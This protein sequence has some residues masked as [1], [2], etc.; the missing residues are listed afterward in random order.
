MVKQ[1]VETQIKVRDMSGAQVSIHPADYSSWGACRTDLMVSAKR[2]IKAKMN[3]ALATAPDDQHAAI[4]ATYE[5][6][7]EE[8]EHS[9][10]YEPMEVH[11]TLDVAYNFL[12]T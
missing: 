12:A 10:D 8:K 1:Q 4:R 3:S 6:R 5:L 2:P 7:Q 9:I 11:M